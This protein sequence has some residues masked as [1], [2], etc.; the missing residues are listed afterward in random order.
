MTTAWN[1]FEHHRGPYTLHVIRETP[2]RKVT[3]HSEALPGHVEPEDIPSEAQALLDDPR[4]TITTVIVFSEYEQQHV[5]SYKRRT[6]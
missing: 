4:D 3:W 2:T 1:P 6:V 5:T